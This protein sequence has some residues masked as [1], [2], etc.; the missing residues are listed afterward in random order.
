MRACEF[1]SV[2]VCLEPRSSVCSGLSFQLSGKACIRTPLPHLFLALFTR[3][4]RDL[5]A[6]QSFEPPSKPRWACEVMLPATPCRWPCPGEHQASG[7]EVVVLCVGKP[8]W[9]S[10]T[11]LGARCPLKPS[12]ELFSCP[13]EVQS[14]C[15]CWHREAGT[16]GRR[17]EGGDPPASRVHTKCISQPI[18][19]ACRSPFCSLL[20][21]YMID[22]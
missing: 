21:L 9:H 7:A 5:A 14:P 12:R 18:P 19:L 17:G 16:W 22:N 11:P 10:Q 15:G 13:E 2:C 20:C 4:R 6:P 1:P 8:L 3:R